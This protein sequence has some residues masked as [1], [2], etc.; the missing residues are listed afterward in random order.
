MKTN[1]IMQ[2]DVLEVLRDLPAGAFDCAITSPPYWGLRDYGVKGQMGLEKTPEEFI[3]KM[4]AVF[5]EVRRT[6]RDDGTL[7]LNIGDS[8]ATNSRNGWQG[9]NSKVNGERQVPF[10]NHKTGPGLKDKDLVGIPWMLAF[11]LRADG[12][13]LRQDI[14]WAKPNPMPESVSDRC[15]KSHEYVFLLSKKERYYYD[16]DAIREPLSQASIAR[17]SEP[18]L[19]NQKG[20]DRVPGKHNGRMKAVGKAERVPTGWHQSATG[21]GK[22]PEYGLTKGDGFAGVSGNVRDDGVYQNRNKRS[23]WTVTTKP[24]KDAHFATFPEDLIIP[25]VRAGSR[26]KGIVL[27]PFMGAGTTGLVAKKLGREYVGIELNPDYV[28]LA[29]RRIKEIGTPFL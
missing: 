19:M 2:G 25:M 10:A 12:W 27:D 9:K 7:W 29:D 13:Y 14:I 17:L 4:V 16:C 5:A 28:A 24:F 11:A 26:A 8:Y 1:T 23:V 20:S 21:W 15:T 18:N 3:K 22:L 6:L